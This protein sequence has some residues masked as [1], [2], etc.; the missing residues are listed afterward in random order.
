MNTKK[1]SYLVVFTAMILLSFAQ[2]QSPVE[3]GEPEVAPAT[4]VDEYNVEIAILELDTY[5]ELWLDATLAHKSDDAE[6]LEKNLFGL[7]SQNIFIYQERV[8]Q[9]ASDLALAGAVEENYETEES[10]NLT[11]RRDLFQKAIDV[12]NTKEAIF[13]SISNTGAFSNK[14]RLLGDYID[15]L[16]RELKMSRLKLAEVGKA[17]SKIPGSQNPSRPEEK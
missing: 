9:M 16:R 14:Y 1:V 5:Y 17:P 10:A 13:R 3:Q 4:A 8:R 6:N 15:L 2:A 11:E 7:V 12:L